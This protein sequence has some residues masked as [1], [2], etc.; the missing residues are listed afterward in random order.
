MFYIFYGADDLARDEALNAILSRVPDPAM[1]ELNTTRLDGRRTTFPELRHSCDTIPFLAERRIVIVEGLLE[2][3]KGGPKEFADQLSDYLGTL[4]AHA[5]LFL[6]EGEKIDKRTALWKR[7]VKF[8][9]AKKGVIREFEKPKREALPRWIQARTR[10]KSGQ[11]DAR[12]A[13]ELATFVGD[14]L[15]LLD[16]EIDKLVTYAGGETITSETVQL[17]VPYTAEANIFGLMDAISQRDPRRALTSLQ[18]LLAEGAAP[19]YLHFMLT[20]QIRI[21]L[22]VRELSEFGST[23]TEIRQKLALH[24][25]IVEKTLKQVGKFSLESLEAAFERLL[26]A[27][28]AMKTGQTE[29]ELGLQLLVADLASGR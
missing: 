27:D 29:P 18:Q 4:P 3:L 5:R 28:Q 15:R 11:I 19:P 7:A 8:A 20:R 12:A 1:A 6:I 24:P 25:F 2:R 21:L 9:E 13:A 14:D 23:S 17:L 10:Q 26:E 16:S 22:Q